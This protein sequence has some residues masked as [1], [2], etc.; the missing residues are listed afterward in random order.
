MALFNEGLN[1]AAAELQAMQSPAYQGPGS[2]DAQP[3]REM[4]MKERVL[5]HHQRIASLEAQNADL[6]S[7]VER[8]AN[9][10]VDQFGL[11]IK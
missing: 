2:V 7:A 10:L 6:R 1:K 3:A 9:M 4:N 5:D 11:V 8:L